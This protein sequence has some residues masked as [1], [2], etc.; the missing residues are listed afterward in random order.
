MKDWF[1]QPAAEF[2]TG[3]T[4]LRH[5]DRDIVAAATKDGRVLL[6]DAASLGG[7]GSR[8]AARSVEAVA[9]RRRHR[10]R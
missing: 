5:N 6:L 8:D 9:R 10:R 7:I 4:I 2:V 1:T 3:P